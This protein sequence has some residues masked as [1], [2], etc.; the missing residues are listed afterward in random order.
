MSIE[1]PLVAPS[2]QPLAGARSSGASSP[3]T[4]SLWEPQPESDDLEGLAFCPGRNSYTAIAPGRRR[5]DW[6]PDKTRPLTGLSKSTPSSIEEPAKSP[7][8]TAIEAVCQWLTVP[9][10]IRSSPGFYD[11]S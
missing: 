3:G 2:R 6:A 10:S 8:E 11:V 5:D 7:V 1:T 9:E 4:A